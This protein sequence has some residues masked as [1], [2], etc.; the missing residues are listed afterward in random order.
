MAKADGPQYV[1]TQGE[2]VAVNTEYVVSDT[3]RFEMLARDILLRRIGTTGRQ[4]IDAC[5][6]LEELYTGPLY[7]PNFGDSSFYVRQRRIYQA[8]FVD[9]MMRGIATALELDDLP[10]H[11]GSSRRRCARPPCART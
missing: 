9:C 3:M 1:L 5:L 7:V 11:H 2:G 10:S 6:Q 4:L 8:K